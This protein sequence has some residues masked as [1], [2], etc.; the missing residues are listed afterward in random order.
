MKRLFTLILAAAVCG[1]VCLAEEYSYLPLKETY[2]NYADGTW[3]ENFRVEYT[4]DDASRLYSSSHIIP[5]PGTQKFEERVQTTFDNLNRAKQRLAMRYDAASDTWQNVDKQE[6]AY[7]D[8]VL[9]YPIVYLSYRWTE[10]AWVESYGQKK[11]IARNDKGIVV[12]NTNLMPVSGGGYAAVDKTVC[13]TSSD[14]SVITAIKYY[15]RPTYI[16]G[17]TLEEGYDLRDIV[18]H[19]T[20]GQY[21]SFNPT[22]MSDENNRMSYAR[23][24]I[25]GE[26]AGE[27]TGEYRDGGYM[28]KMINSLTGESTE[29]EFAITDPLTGSYRSVTTETKLEYTDDISDLNGDGI[30]NDDDRM[31]RSRTT[32][33]AYTFDEHGRTIEERT[34]I[35]RDGAVQAE[36]ISVFENIYD[37]ANHATQRTVYTKQTADSEPVPAS[38]IC[39]SDFYDFSAGVGEVV[40]DA[41]AAVSVAGRTLTVSGAAASTLTVVTLDGK[42]VAT[43][44]GEGSYTVA[45]DGL[46]AGVYVAAVR[47]GGGTVTAK[48]A[49]R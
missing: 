42:T 23:L 13:A 16:F 15:Y 34:K 36:Y 19:S 40:A 29:K 22:E 6:Y 46:A 37:E 39:Y 31:L 24:Y 1:G 45:L 38:R 7:D 4:V 20:D 18:W 8:V 3:Y 28:F 5:A 30:I 9:T 14:G 47:T 21:L 26:P 27:L 33:M 41:K 2:Y 12:S 25:G 43:A 11:E 10:N 35:L 49:L 17:S 48:I 44:A 32:E